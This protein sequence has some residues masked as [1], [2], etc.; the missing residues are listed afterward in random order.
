MPANNPLR[1]LMRRELLDRAPLGSFRDRIELYEDFRKAPALASVLDWGGS[2][3]FTQA[4]LRLYTVANKDFI[5]ADV[6]GTGTCV[7]NAHGGC[8]LS[9]GGTT[10]N[11]SAILPLTA[12]NS[13][14]AS[15]WNT[16]NWQANYEVLLEWKISLPAITSLEVYAGLCLTS[17][18]DLTTDDDQ[19]MFQFA[20]ASSSYWEAKTSIGG[21]DAAVT[22]STG[23]V[24]ADK[25]YILGIKASASRVPR[26]YVNGT[27]VATGSALTSAVNLLPMVKVKTLTGSAKSVD[28]RAVRLSRLPYAA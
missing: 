21:T 2:D 11:G 12:I 19:A 3:A 6:A 25:E 13:V 9:S 8:R 7:L 18:L 15:L 10:N 4:A 16:I 1:E 24:A 5:R 26:F 28:V 23:A 22:T 17:A 20:P 14:A 27:K